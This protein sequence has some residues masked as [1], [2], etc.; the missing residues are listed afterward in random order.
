VILSDP[1]CHFC[2]KLH[3]ETKKVLAKDPSVSFTVLLFSRSNDPAVAKR[4]AAALCGGTEE[5]LDRAYDGKVPGDGS[6]GM[7]RVAEIAEAAGKLALRGTPAMIFPDGRVVVGY[8]DTDTV[9]KIL[10]EAQA[11]AEKGDGK[12]KEG[13]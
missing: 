4:A 7:D 5:A 12:G 10:G 2:Q 13:K 8:R 11:A 9:L 6:C 3:E 1:D